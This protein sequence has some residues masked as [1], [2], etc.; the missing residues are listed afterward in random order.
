VRQFGC[1]SFSGSFLGIGLSAF[2]FVS[3]LDADV[4]GKIRAARPSIAHAETFGT[5]FT[6]GADGTAL[7]RHSLILMKLRLFLFLRELVD[8]FI[9][10]YEPEVFAGDTFQIAAVALEC[11]DFP[12][13]LFIFAL[14]VHEPGINFTF[15][16]LKLVDTQQTFITED[17]KEEDENDA[18]RRDEVHPFLES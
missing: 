9:T 10:A 8:N 3:V 2:V 7:S 11:Q 4:A 1:A 5:F 16:L 14:G 15:I 6:P 18:S 13:Q 17:G 12:L